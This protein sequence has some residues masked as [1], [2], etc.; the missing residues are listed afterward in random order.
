MNISGR[1]FPESLWNNGS[2]VDDVRSFYRDDDMLVQLDL[3]AATANLSIG[4]RN[5]FN[6]ELIGGVVCM[7]NPQQMLDPWKI[8]KNVAM[9]VSYSVT[10]LIGVLGNVTAMMGM[11]G[12]RKSRNATTLFLVSLSAADLLLLLVCAPL[13]AL[14][15]FVIQWDEAGTICKLAKYAEVLSAVASVLN[16]TAVSLERHRRPSFTSSY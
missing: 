15:Y 6:S 14:Q 4:L 1:L 10:F 13:E 3:L 11:I 2:E 9:L 8:N 16:L 7:V 12:D 5:A